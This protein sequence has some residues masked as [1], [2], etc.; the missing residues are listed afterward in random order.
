VLTALA[1][2]LAANATDGSAQLS[3]KVQTIGLLMTTIGPDHPLL[4]VLRRSL[5]ELGYV[6]GQ[7]VRFEFR[8]AYGKVDQLPTLAKELAQLNVGVIVAAPDP[9]VLVAK[10][11]IT[12]APIAM[13]LFNIDPVAAG[14]VESFSRPGGNI[15]GI[16]GRQAELVAKR[17]ELLREVL[18]RLSR[19]GALYDATGASHLA[20]LHSAARELGIELVHI[21]LRPPYHLEGAFNAARDANVGAV[22][23]LYSLPSFTRREEFARLALRR[24]LPTM[25]FYPEFVRSGGLMSYGI[26]AEAAFARIAYFIDRILKGVKPADLPVEQVASFKLSINLKTAKAL[27]ITIPESILLRADEVIR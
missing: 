26:E 19:V 17:L 12:T 27:G 21:E 18:P 5:N 9:A 20:E 24:R 22:V 25:A 3:E 10:R 4:Q 11:T 8:S 6:E 16:Y 2:L 14:V 15:T 23:V 13:L 1:A 7:N